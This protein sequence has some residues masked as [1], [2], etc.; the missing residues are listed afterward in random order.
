MTLPPPEPSGAPIARL[1]FRPFFLLASLFGVLSLMVWLAFWHGGLLLRPHG[2]SMW[3]HQHE[4]L[5]GFGAAVVVGFLL[6][7]AQ[8]WTGQRSLQ[9]W[10]LLGLVGVWLAARLLLAFPMGLPAGLLM[11][12]DLAFLP[13]A[14]LALGQMVLAVR[15]WRNLV[16][17]PILLLLAVANLAM[18][19]GVMRGQWL[20]IREGGYL[21][22]LLIAALMVMLGGRVIPFFTSR[23]L[24]R[25]RP[26]DWPMLERL[27]L[28]SIYAVVLVQLAIL[29]SIELP[30]GLLGWAMLV[31][32]G[33]NGVRLARW[34]GWRTLHEP[35]L[36]GLHFSYAFIVVGLVMWALA[37]TGVFRVE[38]AV[39]ALAIGGIG[40]MMLAMMA[41]VALGHTGREIRTLPGIG[42][43]LMLMFAGALLRSPVLAMFPQITHW[44][45]S[46]SI[47]FWCIAFLIFLFHYTVPLLTTRVDGKDG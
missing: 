5:F 30:P 27:S 18:H 34:E 15:Q 23:K 13:L 11:V 22:V 12:I 3:W 36:W 40:S 37:H 17:V 42:I 33:A 45:Y 41:R 44:T 9:G 14:A 25:Q 43:G 28:W 35:L 10:L 16:F 47:L 2:G 24:G 19:I 1:A 7:A 29:L 38:L 8:N 32:A 39:H 46:V 6:T 20:L 21:A 4:M 31:A 26:A